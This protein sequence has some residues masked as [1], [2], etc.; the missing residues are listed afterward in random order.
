MLWLAGILFGIALTT[1]LYW[2][3]LLLGD[4]RQRPSLDEFNYVPAKGPAAV[5][6]LESLAMLGAFA[7]FATSRRR[8]PFKLRPFLLGASIV[9]L[10]GMALCD[11]F[12]VPGLLSRP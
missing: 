8:L 7:Y 2:F 10:G 12:A 9:A 4:T 11:V 6:V 3:G 1:G 5:W